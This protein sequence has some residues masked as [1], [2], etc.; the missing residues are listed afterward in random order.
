MSE[1]F[2][3]D[4]A[5]FVQ[6]S[7]DWVFSSFG[8][9][10]FGFRPEDNAFAAVSLPRSI[11][12]RRSTSMAIILRYPLVLSPLRLRRSH[13]PIPPQL[14]L[15]S[16]QL[17]PN[18]PDNP[19]LQPHLSSDLHDCFSGHVHSLALPLL[20]SRQSTCHFREILAVLG[21]HAAF[22]GTEDLFLDESETVEG[23]L[24]SVVR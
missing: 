5:E 7:F 17:R 8:K 9:F 16:R 6:G 14:Q 2:F 1:A 22:R 4:L 18:H 20:L 23:G 13:V 21:V 10:N 15:F 11:L 12:I 24:L 19:L 3:A